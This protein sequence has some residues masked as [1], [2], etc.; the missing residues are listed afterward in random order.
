MVDQ[1][2]PLP[3]PALPA[4]RAPL[5]PKLLAVSVAACFGLGSVAALANPSGATVVSGSA[6]FATSGSQLTV[7][8]SPNAII[9]WQS[10]S[11]GVN[12]I[13]RFVQQNAASAVLNRVVGSG[14]VVPQSVI[15]GILSSNGRVFLMNNS[16]VVF[17]PN[18]R[19]DV[20]GLIASSL[21]M[22]NEDFLAGRMRFTEVLGAGG[23]TNAGLIE[24]ANGGRVFLVAPDVKNSGIIRAP[25][26][27]IVLAAGKSVELV[28]EGSPYVTVKVTNSDTEQALNM[29]SLVSQGGRISLGA[30]LVRN[31]GVV[32][33][34][35]AVVGDGGVIRL[36]GTKDVTLDAGSRLSA[37]GGSTG[38]NGGSITV[39]AET[40]TTL[41]YGMVDATASAGHGGTVQALGVR[42]GVVGNGVIDA[43][44]DTGGGTVLVGGDY[45]GKNIDVQNAQRTLI[46]A[47]GVIRADAG[48]AGDG[49]RVI[50]WADGDTRVAGTISTRGGSQSGNGGF[51]ETSGKVGLNVDGARID[52]RAPNGSWGNWLLDPTDVTIAATGAAAV[53]DIDNFGDPGTGLTIASGTISS[54][55]SSSGQ[56]TIQASNNITFAGDLTLAY[57]GGPTTGLTLQAGN[58]I[59]LSNKTISTNGRHVTMTAN[60]NAYGTASGTGSILGSGTIDTSGGQGGNITLSGHGIALTALRSE[61]IGYGGG[62]VSL[63]AD[64]YGILI[65]GNIQTKGGTVTAYVSG[66]GSGNFQI[67]DTKATHISGFAN[68]TISLTS[69]SGNLTTKDLITKSD[70]AAFGA[71][72]VTVDASS[73]NVQIN[74]VIDAAGYGGGGLSG[75]VAVYGQNVQVDKLI[76]TIRGGGG[77]GR[78]TINASQGVQLGGTGFAGGIKAYGGTVTINAFT[79]ITVGA[80]GWLSDIDSSS[81][82]SGQD[83][84]TITMQIGS[85]AIGVQGAIRAN[86]F[87]GTA[88]AAFAGSN[89]GQIQLIRTSATAPGAGDAIKVTGAIQAWGGN[90][91]VS[92]G[93]A[94]GSGGQ[95]AFVN[96]FDGSAGFVA[97]NVSL[98]GGV[99]NH[100]GNGASATVQLAQGGSGNKGENVRVIATGAVQLG[101]INMRGG[102]AGASGDGN[103]GGPGYGGQS[104]GDAGRVQVFGSSI[105]FN[106]VVDGTAGNGGTGAAGSASYGPANG[107]SGGTILNGGSVIGTTGSLFFGGNFISIGGNGGNAGAYNGSNALVQGNGG[108]GGAGGAI[109]LSGT[110]SSISFANTG[111]TINTS[112]GAGGAASTT[113]VTGGGGTGGNAGNIQLISNATNGAIG[114][115]TAN[116]GVGGT[117]PSNSSG[118]QG[119]NAGS[120]TLAGFSSVGS[121]S[122]VGG[123]A[124]SGNTGA[125]G[126][127]AG[128]I[129][130]D[131]LQGTVTGGALSSYAGRNSDNTYGTSGLINISADGAVNETGVVITRGLQVKTNATTAGLTGNVTVANNANQIDWA[132]IR[133]YAGLSLPVTG[134]INYAS[135]GFALTPTGVFRAT[136]DINISNPNPSGGFIMNGGYSGASLLA[137]S[138]I[139][140]GGALNLVSDGLSAT[141]ASMNTAGTVFQWFPLTNSLQMQVYNSGLAQFSAPMVKFG[142]VANTGG[143][144]LMDAI[145]PAS[146]Q[147]L[148]LI[149]GGQI[150]TNGAGVTVSVTNLNADGSQVTL[151][152]TNNVVQLQGQARAGN[153]TFSNSGNI[154]LGISDPGNGITGVSATGNVIL[155]SVNG[156]IVSTATAVDTIK[157]GTGVQL[158]ALNGTLGT[159]LAPLS[160]ATPSFLAFSKNG[161]YATLNQYAPQFVRAQSIQNTTAGDI[162]LKL[163]GGGQFNSTVSNGGT[164]N[165][166]ILTLS[167]LNVLAGASSG[168]NMALTTSGASNNGMTLDGTFTVGTN[169]T[170]AVTVGTGG[171]LTKGSNF[172][173]TITLLTLPQSTT[174]TSTT[175][176]LASP[177]VS[178]VIATTT[179]KEVVQTAGISNAT[180]KV[181]TEDDKKKKNDEKKQGSGK[182]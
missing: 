129:T 99:D 5:R 141:T 162:A 130:I 98:L 152:G 50:V 22:S 145:A 26:G 6:S 102:N 44:G 84:G 108:G 23:V 47:N 61:G 165:I 54:A 126:G 76:S 118:G 97:G 143:L 150:F 12:E 46:G 121:V 107:G 178:Q 137:G 140:A 109:Q 122:A 131:N 20:A 82:A 27:E 114:A 154:V 25:Q 45:Q 103:G 66:G 175:A 163:Y 180:Q 173:G 158:G 113:N 52:T 148:S 71:G 9:N 13:T 81:G 73:G 59:D 91:A 117:A 89:G 170:F 41:V 36:V 32:E 139:S 72:S 3:V 111:I 176:A 39:Q 95:G 105:A 181:E 161:M 120:V 75:N 58:N 132:S 7:T 135:K 63:S 177:T 57:S 10:F 125:I 24:A 112:G 144:V 127:T 30:A 78:V 85:G 14:G 80:S 51:I 164:G 119:G 134:T 33:A 62:N 93:G 100:G 128:T 104:G 179:S 123:Q 2:R 156:S 11:I 157:G 124:G 147:T 28:T 8:N 29:G 31:T 40:G 88:G 65:G 48:T 16:G 43:S 70:Q 4:S 136:G 37:T 153:F 34:G 86:G 182:C 1:S 49:G 83:A 17:G 69:A 42:V 77:G 35:G 115:V 106:S 21:N 146:V 169:G 159:A 172:L 90:G 94:G 174:T 155:S 15:D 116:G 79:G 92:I 96:V 101:A 149:N 67:I 171:A 68:G 38:G 18:A 166:D 53:T 56:I 74:G 55:F 110:P 167:P 19:I 168:G 151:N 87:D 60:D 138:G 133:S 64:S 142:N 160:I